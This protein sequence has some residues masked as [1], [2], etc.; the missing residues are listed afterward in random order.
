MLHRHL[1]RIKSRTQRLIAIGLVILVLE[2]AFFT[3]S[4][5]NQE[6]IQVFPATIGRDCAPWDGG[7]FTT[8]VRYGPTSPII[9]SIWKS[10]DIKLP[11]TFS[12]PDETGVVG[13]A[14]ILSETDSLI[15]LSGQVFFRRVDQ[16]SP[17]V[18]EF[19]LTDG[20][21][22]PFKGQFNTTWKHE[23]VACG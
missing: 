1:Y 5:R 13:H 9:V 15:P 6:T 23:A 3:F 2:I 8:S 7:A 11:T 17:V 21:G 22:K 12:F 19:N 18:G 10:P 4:K 20:D 16:E 14:Y